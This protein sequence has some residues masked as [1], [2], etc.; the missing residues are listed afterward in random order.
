MPI[1][2]LIFFW[3]LKLIINIQL[4]NSHISLYFFLKISQNIKKGEN[5]H[6]SA[7]KILFPCVSGESPARCHPIKPQIVEVTH[8]LRFCFSDVKIIRIPR[9]S[10]VRLRFYNWETH[11]HHKDAIEWSWGFVN[12]GKD[13]MRER[14][15]GDPCR[16]FKG[17][18]I[19]LFLK[20]CLLP[21]SWFFF[22]F[23]LQ[24][25]CVFIE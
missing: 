10:D 12:E 9:P 14:T 25:S 6:I 19:P 17:H 5:I 23:Y 11:E 24:I 18:V 7:V 2:K 21:M 13:H 1:K 3:S 22:I 4:T 8:W 16:F 15:T 20:V